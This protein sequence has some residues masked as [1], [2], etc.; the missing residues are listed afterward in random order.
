[1]VEELCTEMGIQE[2]SEVKEFSIHASRDKGRWTYR[3]AVAI[4]PND[5]PKLFT[6]NAQVDINC[7]TA[8]RRKKN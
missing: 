1:M 6:C 3:H 7:V 2:P 8:K 4:N 5:S